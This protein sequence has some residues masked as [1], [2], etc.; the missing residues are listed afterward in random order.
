MNYADELDTIIK[1]CDHVKDFGNA[2]H[3]PEMAS[4]LQALS[5]IV[6]HISGKEVVTSVNNASS[7]FE[8]VTSTLGA[9][10]D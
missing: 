7:G 2:T 3:V 4:M 5:L 9:P 8:L 6:K 10:N 1:R